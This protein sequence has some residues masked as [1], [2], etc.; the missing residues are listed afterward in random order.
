MIP[1]RFVETCL[2]TASLF[3]FGVGCQDS[4]SSGS[5]AGGDSDGDSDGDTDTDSDSDSDGECGWEVMIDPEDEEF[6]GASAVWGSSPSSVFAAGGMDSIWHYDGA[7]WSPMASPTDEDFSCE[8]MWGSADDDVYMV[9]YKFVGDWDGIVAR[10]DGD[11][12]F[13]VA[14]PDTTGLHGIWGSAS[15]DIWVVGFQNT[16]L[17]FDG[18]QWAIV[19]YPDGYGFDYYD[20]WGSAGN[21]VHVVGDSNVGW[22]GLSLHYDGEEWTQLPISD[23]WS[24]LERVWGATPDSVYAIRQQGNECIVRFD[25]VGWGP[26]EDCG[27]LGEGEKILTDLRAIGG[28]AHD[29]FYIA[30]EDEIWHHKA[31]EWEMEYDGAPSLVVVADFWIHSETDVFAV[32]AGIWHYGCE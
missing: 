7:E 11:E 2:L 23:L 3:G 27:F 9:G 14:I 19:D 24:T 13:E 6:G 26:F 10:F 21:D 16:I 4:G 31:G 28:T 18:D 8:G 1:A 22:V 32:G 15:G 5:D 20:I 29:D 17:H 25:G 30:D 12:W